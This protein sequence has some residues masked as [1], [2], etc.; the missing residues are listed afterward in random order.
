[1]TMEFS[2][3]FQ[4]LQRDND[5]VNQKNG[6]CDL[7]CFSRKGFQELNRKLKLLVKVWRV[8]NNSPNTVMHLIETGTVRQ[9]SENQC[10]VHLPA[11]PA[12]VLQEK[13]ERVGFLKTYLD[14][15]TQYAI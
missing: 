12:N 15:F 1:M 14:N 2:W 3:L 5:T 4:N 13:G 8:N 6:E 11:M 9:K 7:I 10:F